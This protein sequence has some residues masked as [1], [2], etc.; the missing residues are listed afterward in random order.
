MPFRPPAGWG[1]RAAQHDLHTL[2]T[3]LRMA[4]A[5]DPLGTPPKTSTPWY[6]AVARAGQAWGL[7]LNDTIGDCTIADSANAVM[8]ATANAGRIVVPSDD[9]VRRVYSE[10]SGWD[11]VLG[12]PTDIG[13]YELAV[14]AYL[15]VKGL[16]GV[17][18]AAYG[19]L[20]PKNLDHVRWAIQLFGGVRFGFR[21][22][23]SAEEQFQA[24][25]PMTVVPGSTIVGGHDMRGIGYAPGW[26]LLLTWGGYCWASEGFI[27]T[28]ADEAHAEL[29]EGWSVP[30]ID[31]A[32]LARDL[33]LV[34]DEMAS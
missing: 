10:I 6:A 5:L 30:G 28:F 33:A 21:L 31:T 9:E 13:C 16:A 20:D 17:R 27:A 11:G 1:K 2:R 15:R 24:G 26:V 14:D 32:T 3:A 18:L 34:N 8:I 12:S 22:P 25:E 19:S 23:Q 7:H 4:A 29:F